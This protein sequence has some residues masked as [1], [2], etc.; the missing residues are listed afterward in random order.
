MKPPPQLDVTT[1]DPKPR[2]RHLKDGIRRAAWRDPG[3]LSER[4]QDAIYAVI[5]DLCNTTFRVDFAPYW[6][7]R[8]ELNYLGALA[9]LTLL[10]TPDDEVIGFTSYQI[11]DFAG[12]RTLYV[13]STCVYPPYQ[14]KG[15]MAPLFAIDFFD[16]HARSPFRRMHMIVR[17]ENPIVYAALA[18]MLGEEQMYP[19]P[20]RPVPERLQEIASSC[21]EWLACGQAA[22]HTPSQARFD[23]ATLKQADAY[24]DPLYQR[25]PRSGVRPLDEFFH[26]QVTPVD[27]FLVTAQVLWRELAP[28]YVRQRGVNPVRAKLSRPRRNRGSVPVVRP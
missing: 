1:L 9:N 20:K 5:V 16:E 15:L 12:A 8:R 22:V 24:E 21:A 13:D 10:L 18:T 23:P 7:H 14:T 3:A 6:E 19:S 26:A 11:R 2:T 28:F 25:I 27:A 17:T 4:D